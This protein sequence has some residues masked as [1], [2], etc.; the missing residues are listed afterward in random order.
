MHVSLFGIAENLNVKLQTKSIAMDE[1]YMTQTIVEKIRI[2][3]KSNFML[4][5]K[6]MQ[7]PTEMEDE[8]VRS[9]KLLDLSS[10]NSPPL[11]SSLAIFDHC[12]EKQKLKVQTL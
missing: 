1:I 7:Y 3:N 12:I 11:E 9:R 4:K 8:M 6:W 2:E 10:T 5:F